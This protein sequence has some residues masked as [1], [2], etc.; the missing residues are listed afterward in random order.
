MQAGTFMHEIGHTFGLRHGGGDNLNDKPNYHSVMNY[1]WQ[2]PADLPA[3]ATARQRAYNNSWVLDYSRSMWPELDETDL[4]ENLGIGGHAGHVLPGPWAAQY[5]NE[6]GPVDWSG[7]DDDIDGNA[8]NETHV[9]VDVNIDG[10]LDVLESFEDWSQIRYYFR[11]SA[12]F[13]DGAHGDSP[14][15]EMTAEEYVSRTVPDGPSAARLV[16]YNNSTFD[17]NDLLADAR[18]DVAVDA[19]KAALFA[20]ETPSFDNVSTYARGINGLMID[21][22]LPGGA[23]PT[24]AD[25]A[26]EV[27]RA[28]TWI[29]LAAAP[30]VSVRPGAGFSGT[31]RVT[32][33]LPDGAVR[34]TWL[35][36]TV[37][38]TANTG[39]ES[40]DVFH[41][42]HLAGE[43]G[44]SAA[45]NRL[46]VTP[47]DF[48]RTR[49]AMGAAAT[50]DSPY[51]FNRDGRV[52]PLDLSVVRSALRRSLAWPAAAV[53]QAVPP[54]VA[55]SSLVEEEE[56]AL[57]A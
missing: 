16:F 6:S 37:R 12:T 29:P 44:D 32:L 46:S 53:P 8:S 42:G 17:G 19:T 23:A 1:T 24:A 13:A 11:E 49:R 21:L 10:A 34:N 54:P 15:D 18:D 51:D 26:L 9:V 56:P 43:T 41:F 36:V 22:A 39:L 27:G 7:G 14:D 5:V 33:V 48:L 38:A 52:S 28:G 25:F 50:L 4:D 20:G 31:D 2:M 55:S 40:P 3:G 57:W 30:A 35:R 47:V 45:G